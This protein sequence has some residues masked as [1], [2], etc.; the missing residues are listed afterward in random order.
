[1]DA[2]Y[3]SALERQLEHRHALAQLTR[4][5]KGNPRHADI[6]YETIDAYTDLF[7][8]GDPFWWSTDLL[9]VLVAAANAIGET[10]EVTEIPPPVEKGFVWLET[11]LTMPCMEHPPDRP[12]T[13]LI[14]FGWS[15]LLLT[16]G[17]GPDSGSLRHAQSLYG[18]VQYVE[19][20]EDGSRRL[21]YGLTFAVRGEAFPAVADRPM[22]G[23]YL[24]N[25]GIG[26]ALPTQTVTVAVLYMAACRFLSQRI[27]VATQQRVDRAARR[28]LERAGYEHEPIVRVIELRRREHQA[29]ETE[30]HAD[31]EWSCQWIVRGHWHRYRTKEGLQPR[32]VAPY[33]KGPADA[34]LKRPRAEVFAVVR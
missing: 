11:P 27:V 4:H 22:Q 31:V 12:C 21:A 3:T 34:P 5:G 8:Y 32:W 26:R 13:H 6:D 14:G 10:D 23:L 9:D 2:R 17:T 19:P 33:V 16:T 24:A 25:D 20:D 18:L 1:M 7:T 28:R 30:D 15:P 29:R